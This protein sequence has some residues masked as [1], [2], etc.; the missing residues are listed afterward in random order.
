[1]S[2]V[3][4]N[5]PS[6]MRTCPSRTSG[7]SA[8]LISFAMERIFSFLTRCLS[9]VFIDGDGRRKG[10][11]IGKGALGLMATW[12]PLALPGIWRNADDKVSDSTRYLPSLTWETAYMTTKKANSSVMKSA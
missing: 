12:A 3:T 11:A 7:A 4:A 10:M 2:T 5:A 9:S 1:M 8:S 6:V